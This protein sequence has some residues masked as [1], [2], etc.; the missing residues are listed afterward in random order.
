MSMAELGETPMVLFKRGKVGATGKFA[1]Q[2]RRAG[3]RVKVAM[4]ADT[5]GAVKSAVREG[6]GIGL[7]YRDSVQQDIARGE[8]QPVEV[9]G[10]DM[11]IDSTIVYARGRLSRMAEEFLRLLRDQRRKARAA[12]RIAARAAKVIVLAVL[13]SADFIYAFAGQIADEPGIVLSWIGC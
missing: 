1:E 7:L 8:L 4:R 6:S 13:W 9:A 5:V 12:A 11:R 3:I 2:M 10:L